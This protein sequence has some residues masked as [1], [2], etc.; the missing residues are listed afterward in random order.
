MNEPLALKTFQMAYLI[1]L[2]PDLYV[3]QNLVPR[4]LALK[5]AV[6]FDLIVKMA[7]TIC[8]RQKLSRARKLDI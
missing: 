4:D 5:V 8:L 3:E 6:K 2:C 1:K 7:R